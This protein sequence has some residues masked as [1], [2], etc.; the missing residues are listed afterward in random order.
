MKYNIK[1]KYLEGQDK[2]ISIPRFGDVGIDVYANETKVIGVGS[3]GVIDT[4]ICLEIPPGFF[5]QVLDR[6]SMSK[7]CHCL[8]GVV[9]SSYRGPLKVVM[10][11]HTRRPEEGE[12]QAS[13]VYATFNSGIKIKKGE[14]IAQIVIH[15]D[16]SQE[17]EI[18]EVTELS[19]TER[20][21]G[22]FG[23]TGG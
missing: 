14:K 16:R 5:I 20:G 6:S 2:R 9:D 13:G 23:S 17:F 21:E 1:V 19:S 10:L 7:Y 18:E 4:G 11:N 12:E 3:I 22:G 8:A 15:K